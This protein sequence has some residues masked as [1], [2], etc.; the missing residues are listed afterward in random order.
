ME[1]VGAVWVAAGIENATSESSNIKHFKEKHTHTL[2]NI[3]YLFH[4]GWLASKFVL[5]SITFI[6]RF[7]L[8]FPVGN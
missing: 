3:L 2:S 8:V 1:E 6:S 5:R 7:N 4:G